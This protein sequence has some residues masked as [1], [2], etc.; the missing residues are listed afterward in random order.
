MNLSA[1]LASVT[2]QRNNNF[3]LL[4]FGAATAVIVSHSFILSGNE[5]NSLPRILGF[6]A[7]NCFF[8]ISGFLV[9]KSLLHRRSMGDFAW[10]RILRIYPALV[11][12]VLFCVFVI[13]PF[14]T[15]LPLA[16]YFTQTL[17]YQFLVKNG[18]LVLGGVEYHL[19]GVFNAG[20]GEQKVNAPLWTLFYEIYMYAAI[21]VIALVLKIRPGSSLKLFS[22]VIYL[23]T[24]VLFCIFVVDLAYK[25]F[26][27]PVFGRLVRFGALFGIGASL[28]LARDRI[29]LSPWVFLGMIVVIGLSSVNRT[30]FN[31]AFYLF[32]GYILLYLAYVPGG[33]LLNFNKLGDYSYGLYIFAYPIQQSIVHWFPSTGTMG[34]FVSSFLVTGF[35]AT[36]SWHFV[37]SRALALKKRRLPPDPGSHRSPENA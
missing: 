22:I 6:V 32:L 31:T 11:L 3:N 9:C 5:P 37:E 29:R 33:W 7:V 1:N 13:G 12:A 35:F 10:A 28:Y 24:T 23:L 14:H 27:N 4:R 15:S 8:I 34:L 30:L 26:S 16:E 19:P 2:D 20:P 17:P 36:L 25:I 21:A 18:S